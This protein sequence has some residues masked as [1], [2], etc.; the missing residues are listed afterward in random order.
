MFTFSIDCYDFEWNGAH[1]I[2]VFYNRQN[3]DVFSL[4]YGRDDYSPQEVLIFAYDWIQDQIAW[5]AM[6]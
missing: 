6:I 3:V 4:N 1:T 5:K 2:N